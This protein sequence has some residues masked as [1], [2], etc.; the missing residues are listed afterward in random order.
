MANAVVRA[1]INGQVKREAAAVL[2]EIGLTPSAAFRLMM[3][4]IARDKALPFA[5]LIPTIEAKPAPRRKPRTAT[6]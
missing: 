5:P 4:R 3:I 6:R 1:R 2:T